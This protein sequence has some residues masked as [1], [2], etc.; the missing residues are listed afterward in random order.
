[1]AE[2]AKLRHIKSDDWRSQRRKEVEWQKAV[3][4]VHQQHLAGQQRHAEKGGGL[5]AEEGLDIVMP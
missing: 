1:M 5:R 2:M 3:A 4:E